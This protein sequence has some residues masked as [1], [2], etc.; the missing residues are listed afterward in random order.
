VGLAILV[1]ASLLQLAPVVVLEG[2]HYL[3]VLKLEQ[4]QARVLV[5]PFLQLN[6]QAGNAFLAFFGLY[7]ILIGYLIF[8]STFLPRII[9]VFMSLAGLGYMTFLSPPLAGSPIQGVRWSCPE[10]V[11]CDF[12]DS[13]G[14]NGLSLK[15]GAC[16]GCGS[17]QSVD[18]R[19]RGWLSGL[20]NK[21]K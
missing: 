18:W 14:N 7:C 21:V 19:W 15:R 12:P 9:G 10:S 1:V 8:R 13:R 5:S 4:V 16:P 6:T 20:Q 2:G 17:A 3:S 11:D